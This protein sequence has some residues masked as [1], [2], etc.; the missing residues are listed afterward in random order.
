MNP[1]AQ[2]MAK[3]PL[4]SVLA[5]VCLTACASWAIA[6]QPSVN[7]TSM[8][9]PAGGTIRLELNK[10]T[11]EVVGVA[12]DKITVSWR[13]RSPED[14]RDVTVKLQRSGDKNATILVDGPGNRTRYRIEVPRQSDVA[15]R[16]RAGE[17]EVHGIAGSL[18]AELLAGEMDLRVAEPAHYRNVSASV[19]AGEINAL[20]WRAQTSGL[21]RSLKASGDGE[22]DLRARLLAGQLTIRSE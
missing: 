13:S 15:I 2:I 16:M 21:W 20:P 10:G 11:L 7:P 9:F 4:L 18:D 22:Y 8:S 3:Q 19:T 6:D 1:Q 17:L 12:G 5:L 14:E